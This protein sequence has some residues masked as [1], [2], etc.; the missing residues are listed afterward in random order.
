MRCSDWPAPP[1]IVAEALRELADPLASLLDL[2]APA[3]A[4]AVA[5]GIVAALAATE[6]GRSA[7]PWLLPSQQRSFRRILAALERHGGGLLADPVG[8]GKT[9]VALAVAAAVAPRESVAI[10]EAH[11]TPPWCAHSASLP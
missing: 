8:T 9:Y 7:A 10:V 6:S 5:R 2:P 4:S 1:R 11:L 3:P